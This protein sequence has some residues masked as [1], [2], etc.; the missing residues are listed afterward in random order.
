MDL[1][2]ILRQPHRWPIVVKRFIILWLPTLIY[3][4]IY[5]YIYIYI[6]KLYILH[7]NANIYI[8]IYTYV[9]SGNKHIQLSIY[10]DPILW[11]SQY[12]YKYKYIY[13]YSFHKSTIRCF[14]LWHDDSLLARELPCPMDWYIAFWGWQTLLY[15]LG[16][17]ERWIEVANAN[18]I[19]PVRNCYVGLF[20][21]LNS[22]VSFMI[23]I[24]LE[25]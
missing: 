9:T 22:I 2:I 3:C 11:I 16:S 13:I 4:V 15:Q 20:Q 21:H 25:L 6:H 18:G 19:A 10:L 23:G 12:M 1:L 14:L 8:Y 24:G 7:I 5:T 17:R